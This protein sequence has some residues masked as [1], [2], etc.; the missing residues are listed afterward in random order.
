MI[1]ERAKLVSW[2]YLVTDLAAT[3]AAFGIAH[4]I[5]SWGLTD[6]FGP[7]YPLSDYM[8]LLTAFVLPVWAMV[9]YVCGLYGRRASR[10]LQTFVR[11][12]PR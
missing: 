1:S 2:A 5:R 9:F 6:W 8:P 4:A 3:T 11:P 7:V 10:T 12:D